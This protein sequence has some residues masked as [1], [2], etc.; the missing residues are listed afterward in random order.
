MELLVAETKRYTLLCLGEERCESWDF[1]T[2][3]DIFTYFGV[4]IVMGLIKLPS[5]A[6]Y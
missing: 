1:V 4:M 6:D 2:E 3:E 5:I